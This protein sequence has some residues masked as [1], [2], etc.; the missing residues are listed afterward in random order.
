[1]AGFF[2]TIG[3]DYVEAPLQTYSQ[4]LSANLISGLLPIPKISKSDL[5]R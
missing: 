2:E 5:T 4:D 3:V 1:M